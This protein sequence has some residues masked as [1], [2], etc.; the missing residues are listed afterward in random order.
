MLEM[1]IVP[2]ECDPSA[3]KMPARKPRAHSRLGTVGHRTSLVMSSTAT[4]DCALIAL[5]AFVVSVAGTYEKNVVPTPNRNE[6]FVG[7]VERLVV[8]QSQTKSVGCIS[9]TGGTPTGIGPEVAV[10]TDQTAEIA[11][12]VINGLL[13]GGREPTDTEQR[14]VGGQMRA[15]TT[16]LLATRDV[17]PAPPGEEPV[18]TARDEFRAVFK[19][20][21]VGRL[22]C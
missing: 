7:A 21:S 18:I 8:D 3:S 14:V 10:T 13:R 20:D 6:I 12:A 17:L 4:L 22:D 9:P 16:P 11:P 2:L 5:R 1:R 19:S 15:T